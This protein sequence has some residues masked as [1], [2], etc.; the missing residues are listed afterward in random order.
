M[1]LFEL[2]ALI[3]GAF[4]LLFGVFLLSTPAGFIAIGVVMI[5]FAYVARALEV[6]DGAS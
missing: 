3:V 2:V 1:W 6:N 5:V 4:S